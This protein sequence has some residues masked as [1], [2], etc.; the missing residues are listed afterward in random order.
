MENFD[1]SSEAM[2]GSLADV[3]KRLKEAKKE[4]EQISQE[5]DPEK[6]A[7]VAQKT[8]LLA[9]EQKRLR[10]QLKSTTRSLGGINENLKFQE[11][12]YNQIRAEVKKYKA[13]LG[14]L[15]VGTDEYRKTEA[16]LNNA[17]E[18]EI[19]I[20][21]KQPSLFAKRIRQAQGESK[22][23]KELTT[24]L[25]GLRK[26]LAN[27]DDIKVFDKISKE[28]KQVEGDIDGL[29]AKQKQGGGGG[30]GGL[31]DS[32]FG[33]IVAGGAAG[34]ASK[35]L[36]LV[37]DGLSAVATEIKEI[38]PQL[39]D[40][41]VLSGLSGDA[42]IDL[43][44]AARATS[45]TFGVEF[46][47]VAESANA[48]TKELGGTFAENVALINEA[49]VFD[50]EGESLSFFREYAAQLG[51]LNITS[52]EAVKIAQIQR[53]EGFFDDK[54]FDT[55]KEGAL[56]L[57]DLSTAQKDVL[58]T[59]GPIGQ[60]IQ[61]TFAAGDKLG[62]I[63]L[64]AEAINE[65]GEQGKNVQPIISNLFGG[66]GEDLGARGFEVLANLSNINIEL[67]DLQK[68]QLA[69]VESRTEF[70]T[71]L[72]E[73]A[74]EFSSSGSQ[75]EIFFNQL[76]TFG[77]DLLVQ[78]T[79]FF[80]EIGSDIQRIFK[81]FGAGNATLFETLKALYEFNPVFRQ[82]RF[83]LG[84]VG[85]AVR[86]VVDAFKVLIAFG[87]SLNDQL[88]QPIQKLASF[89]SDSFSNISTGLE[90]FNRG[91]IKTFNSILVGSA[92]FVGNLVSS[93]LGGI[94]TIRESL[95]VFGEFI[96]ES[97]EKR[98]NAFLKQEA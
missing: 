30:G 93:I 66:P 79:T 22:E 4:F 11:G 36:E 56:R 25:R 92:E 60:E 13:A 8:R 7:Q 34:I 96:P 1:K 70:E 48:L 9:T 76:K 87:A 26:E 72:T 98:F 67:T 89:I 18:K 21:E 38:T 61:D 57:G 83:A 94:D 45:K 58:K 51:N 31:I 43:T 62:A 28:I 32:L 29:L 75:F 19:E 71:S 33:G 88:G 20:R 10:D 46:T 6:F 50:P 16:K 24:K 80:K 37:V 91:F 55:I 5:A 63:Q 14:D 47:Q 3:T 84:L 27:T 59:L 65:L 69:L 40:L 44:G 95:G 77:V 73:L 85:D 12:S 39:R 35:G 23:V 53:K 52:E 42:L 68:Q 64:T 41:E 81:F 17:L 86:F 54:L 49:L 90:D 97:L 74:S 82:I 78:L 2:T 15:K